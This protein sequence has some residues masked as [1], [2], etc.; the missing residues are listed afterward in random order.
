MIQHKSKLE[1]TNVNIEVG[2]ILLLGEK[3]R[4]YDRV[5]L[6]YDP[7]MTTPCQG[8][9]IGLEA[10][11][12]LQRMHAPNVEDHVIR[13]GQ[14]LAK[15]ADTNAV[16]RSLSLSLSRLA[17]PGKRTIGAY[18]QKKRLFK[19]STRCP[20]HSQT[21]HILRMRTI[22]TRVLLCCIYLPCPY[23]SQCKI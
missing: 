18:R 20:D 16:T 19:P 15:C 3:L 6:D 8:Y 7:S 5:N 17:R 14:E 10:P 22:I 21:V 11:S 1:N 13:T 9:L 2:S 4:T 23:G 12:Q